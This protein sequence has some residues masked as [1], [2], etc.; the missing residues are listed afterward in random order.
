MRRLDKKEGGP[1]AVNEP[2]QSYGGHQ[3]S[4]Q[5]DNRQASNIDDDLPF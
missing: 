2:G 3:E 4:T 1:G 5:N